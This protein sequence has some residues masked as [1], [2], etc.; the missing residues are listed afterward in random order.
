M[1]QWV[2]LTGQSIDRSLIENWIL[3][4]SKKIAFHQWYWIIPKDHS[5][6]IIL[7]Y[8]IPILPW[9]WN[10]FWSQLIVKVLSSSSS[11]PIFAPL[12][13]NSNYW[14]K[15]LVSVC[16]L[17]KCWKMCLQSQRLKLYSWVIVAFGVLISPTGSLVQLQLQQNRGGSKASDETLGTFCPSPSKFSAKMLRP[18]IYVCY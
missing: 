5:L 18:Q 14:Q 15:A 17:V 11:I 6:S 4:W 16:C 7:T 12:K 1:N 8:V 3:L 9:K 10:V 2:Q 13:S